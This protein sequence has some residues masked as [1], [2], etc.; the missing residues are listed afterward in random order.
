M[1]EPTAAPV[2]DHPSE[3]AHAG[4]DPG[5]PDDP[6]LRVGEREVARYVLAPDLDARHGPRPYL[7]PVRTLAG[8]AV[9][10]ALPADHVWHLGASL[11]VQDVNGT[12]LWGGRTYVRDAGYTWRHDHGRIRHVDWERRDP[13]R[14]AH[15]LHWC[16]RDGG[17]LL[18]EGRRLAARALDDGG[19][20]LD[21]DYTLTAPDDTD[22]TLG[23]P[24]T[25]GR[26]G[27]AGYGGFF[28][29]AVA[30]TP[31][32]V[33]TAGAEG[34]ERVNGSAEPWVVLAGTT[35]AGA[36]Y[37]LLFAGLADGDRW[38]VRS[39]MYPGVCA[40]FAF[41]T[42]RVIPAGTSR[43]GRHRIAVLDGHLD[44]DAAT[45]LAARLDRP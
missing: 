16:D 44:R 26:P 9:T 35:A 29:R 15:R 11:T 10:D 28:W 3:P 7:H 30:A 4:V 25:N 24:A 17:I 45:A 19:W 33:F 23:S 38:F 18:T 1:T 34:E 32:R 8:T 13:G 43:S 14:L 12:N 42:P 40:A 39:S 27:G 22:V 2:T 21:L 37:T 6:R 31:P 41:D 36:A 20:V 5:S